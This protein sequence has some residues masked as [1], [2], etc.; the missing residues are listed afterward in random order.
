L[1]GKL[2][3]SV[4]VLLTYQAAYA[5]ATSNAFTADCSEGD[6]AWCMSPLCR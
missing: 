3:Y 1:Q 6:F 5:V 4:E 2:G